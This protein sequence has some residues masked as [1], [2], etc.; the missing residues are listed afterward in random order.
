MNTQIST[1]QERVI[2][3]LVTDPEGLNMS[4]FSA[5]STVGAVGAVGR[6]RKAACRTTFCLAGLILD[7]SQVCMEYGPRGLAVGLE[8]GE[9]QP[10]DYWIDHELSLSPRLV[11]RS[12]VAIAAKARELW[13][14]AYGEEAAKLLPFYAPDWQTKN[15]A[16]VKPPQV[17]EL[18]QVINE[19]FATESV[20]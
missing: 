11:D 10:A 14:A 8:E 3:R 1:L 2:H 5:V 6:K 19:V 17:I 4:E 20:A 7:E 15:L 12:A 16:K 13:A 18:L 9:E